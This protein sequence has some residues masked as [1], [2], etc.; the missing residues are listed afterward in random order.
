MSNSLNIL[1]S[2]VGFHYGYSCYFLILEYCAEKYD[3]ASTI[4]IIRKR[5]L[6]EMLT[7]S[8]S[9][10]HQLLTTCSS[11]ELF[12]AIEFDSY[13]EIDFPKISEIIGKDY[14]YDR[15]KRV[16]K[17]EKPTLDKKRIEEKRVYSPADTLTLEVV[18]H[19]NKKR[20]SN[21]KANTRITSSLISARKNEGFKLEDFI[22]VINSKCSEWLGTDMEKFLRPETLFGSK[23]EGYL[24]G[25]NTTSKEDL[26]QEL[27][28]ILKGKE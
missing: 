20:K 11:L 17:S 2:K 22:K 6:R 9:R 27:I 4:F 13:Y 5:V 10:L 23:F 28:D 15:R 21:F 19:L 12:K 3:G 1:M 26:D 25:M 18:E 8:S 24:Q 16:V 7:T 14:K